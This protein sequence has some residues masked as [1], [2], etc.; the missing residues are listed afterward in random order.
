MKK[1]TLVIL[2]LA[3]G[4]MLKAQTKEDTI[5]IKK[6]VMD[7]IEGFY[8]AAEKRMENALHP[9]LSKRIMN[10]ETGELR[11][12]TAETL[13]KMTSNKPN[14]ETTKGKMK[15]DIT[16]FDITN[17]IATIKCVSDKFDFIDYCHLGKAK[18]KWKIVNVLWGYPK[19]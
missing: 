3:I 10:P 4:L 6:A 8:T 1:I 14:E 18:G 12:M 19:I 16:I 15:A 13:I 2:A 5:G 7:Y 11:N 9:D 17:G